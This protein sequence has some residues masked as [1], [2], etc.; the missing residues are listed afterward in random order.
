M[1]SLHILAKLEY[2]VI[3]SRRARN[4]HSRVLRQRGIVT[5][6]HGKRIELEV[7]RRVNEKLTTFY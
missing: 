1:E 2:P 6:R 7:Y 4:R 5:L 3:F